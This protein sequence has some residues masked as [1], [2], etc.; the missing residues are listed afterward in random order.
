ML[1]ASRMRDGLDATSKPD[2]GA[3]GANDDRANDDGDADVEWAVA[4]VAWP[5]LELLA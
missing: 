2:G 1:T 3:D 5:R 4:A